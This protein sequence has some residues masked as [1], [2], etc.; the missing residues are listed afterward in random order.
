MS[1][2][3]QYTTGSVNTLVENAKKEENSNMKDEFH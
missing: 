2:Y 1:Q 3:T